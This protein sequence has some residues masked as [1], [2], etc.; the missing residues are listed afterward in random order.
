MYECDNNFVKTSMLKLKKGRY[1]MNM[2]KIITICAALM[3]A[4]SSAVLPIKADTSFIPNDFNAFEEYLSAIDDLS[5]N[6]SM[7]D[8]I[9][10]NPLYETNELDWTNSQVMEFNHIISQITPDSGFN[11]LYINDADPYYQTR[12]VEDNETG[13]VALFETDHVDGTVL[14]LLDGESYILYEEENNLYL[15]NTNNDIIV[16]SYTTKLNPDVSTLGMKDTPYT[17]SDDN[18]YGTDIG[19]FNS[20]NTSLVAFLDWVS[21]GAGIISAT[22]PVLGAVTIIAGG[23]NIIA[24]QS[25]YF[26]SY[27]KYWQANKKTDLSYVREKQRWF[28]QSSCSDASFIKNRTIYFDTARP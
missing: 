8:N 13:A 9:L 12:V 3:L 2:K 5:M 10:A 14:I 18:Q 21:V 19:P 17:L 6:I 22:H 15:K 25:A 20:Q 4:F 27:I 1:N 28:S 11:E 16:V 24:N 7:N 23:L 26:T